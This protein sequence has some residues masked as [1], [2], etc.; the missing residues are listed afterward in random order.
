MLLGDKSEE[1]PWLD[2]IF[3]EV[4]EQLKDKIELYVLRTQYDASLD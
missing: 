2:E 4:A 1:E 3:D